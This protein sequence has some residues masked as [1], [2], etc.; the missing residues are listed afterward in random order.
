M[1]R[2]DLLKIL[3]NIEDEDISLSQLKTL[4]IANNKNYNNFYVYIFY[5]DIEVLYVGQTTNLRKRFV[6]HFR[7]NEHEYWKDEITK[8]EIFELESYSE[9]MGF[10]S[11]LIDNLL[12]VYNKKEHLKNLN[13]KIDY[14]SYF[15]SKEELFKLIEPIETKYSDIL[16]KLE[17]IMIDG[18]EKVILKDWLVD[19]FYKESSDKTVGNC[20]DNIKNKIVDLCSKYN[21]KLV[22]K[23]GNGNKS[24]I[25]KNNITT[26]KDSLI[27]L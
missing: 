17:E 26:E 10:E 18:I 24:Y 5:K 19:E 23:R 9:M 2:T 16:N 4:Y 6:N 7:K 21:Y 1:E 27:V 22:S 11:Y 15:L 13:V 12:P 20:Y 8:V 14:D 3:N 25:I